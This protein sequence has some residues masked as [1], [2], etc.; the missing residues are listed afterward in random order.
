MCIMLKVV[1]LFVVVF[2][3]FKML[4]LKFGLCCEIGEGNKDFNKF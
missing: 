4:L 3:C 1:V 2:W